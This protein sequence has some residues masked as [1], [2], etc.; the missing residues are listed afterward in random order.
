MVF[1]SFIVLN[2][3]LALLYITYCKLT[4][5]IN[6]CSRHLVSKVVIV[7]GSNNGI[8]YETAKDLAERGAR[9]ILAC[10]NDLRGTKARDQI[11][12]ESGNHDVHYRQLDLAS[13]D[14][15]RRF[16]EEFIKTENRLDILINN[17]GVFDV[18]NV[19]TENGL[20]VGMQANH[21]GPFLLTKLLLPLIK[22]SAPSRIINV[23]SLAYS[24]GII[25][26]N[27]LN[28]E[29]ETPQS[30]SKIQAYKNSK[31]CNVLMTTELA[32]R[33]EGTG[34]TANCLHPGLVN[35]DILNSDKLPFS[36]YWLPVTSFFI[37][38][39]R[40]GAQTSIYLAV[41]P[42]VENVTGCYF[43]DCQVKTLTKTGRNTELARR[44]WEESEKI[45]AKK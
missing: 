33:L 37:K 13:F 4:Y 20:F 31:L 30:Y 14:S 5:G 41:S 35:T 23:S 2:L 16:A 6:K 1:I 32:R 26:F 27:N 22:S 43:A 24:K 21:F 12:A 18:D 19:K 36:K 45:I 3:I 34:V 7:T 11:I 17:A 38:T 9:V 44:L 40:E 15:V 25:D 8:G 29:K 39:P 10:R 28:L 42:E